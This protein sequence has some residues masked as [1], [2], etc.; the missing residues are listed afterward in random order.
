MT[1]KNKPASV[2]AAMRNATTPPASTSPAAAAIDN[3]PKVMVVYLSAPASKQLAHLAVD[4]GKTKT[5]IVREAL[6][7][8]FVKHGKLEIAD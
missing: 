2:S 6:N 7:M 5:A 1:P 4:L 3:A 8:F